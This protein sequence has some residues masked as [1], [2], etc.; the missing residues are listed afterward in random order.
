MSFNFTSDYI[1]EDEHVKLMPLH[2]SHSSD[3]KYIAEEKAIWTY[4]LGA[5][6]ASK[7]FEVYI[8][9]ALN[10]RQNKKSYAFT[11]FSKKQN[12][13][14]GS[15]RFF[16][17]SELNDGVRIGYTWYGKAFRGTGINKH[18][19]YLMFDFAFKTMKYERVGLGAHSENKVSI[20]AIKSV[21]CTQE[22]IIR[23]LFP[24]IDKQGRADA[25]LFGITKDDWF[26]TVKHNLK[27]KL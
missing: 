27:L 21:G 9:N 5:S 14:A 11:V 23:S 16:N 10:E 3:L 17:F 24:S 12:K 1:L 26:N 19:K 8:E 15:T 6:D 2:K 7:N 22:G 20:A 4:Y 13:I 18:C 25:V